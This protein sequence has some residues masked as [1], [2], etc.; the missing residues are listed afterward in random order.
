MAAPITSITKQVLTPEE[1]QQQ[2]LAELQT[3]LAD[4]D[5]AIQKILGIAGELNSIGILDAADSMI[6]AKEKIAHIALGQVSREPVTNL[7]NHLMN[8]SAVATRIDPELTTK[9][10]GSMEKGINEGIDF[11]Q[12]DQKTSVF[13]LAKSLK[14][15][16]I[17]RAIGFGLHFLKGMGKGLNE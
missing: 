7:I 2:K 14:D 17:N 6:Q 4:N 10:V 11:L 9:L 13:D 5:E 12:T 3:L 16:D 8:A 1:Q 15:P